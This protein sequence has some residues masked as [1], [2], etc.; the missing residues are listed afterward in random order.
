YDMTPQ[1]A[2]ID[3][4]VRPVEG[5]AR[6]CYAGTVLHTKPQN[7]NATRAPLQLGAEL[8]GHDSIEADVEMV[9]V[10]IGLIELSYTFQGSHLDLGHVG[11][12]RSLV[13]YA[14]LSKIEE[15]E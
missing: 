5:V 10:L 2:L 4:H 11:L 7:F 12:F 14:G 9:D 15:H 6:Y 1:V 8:Y 13:I 3:Y